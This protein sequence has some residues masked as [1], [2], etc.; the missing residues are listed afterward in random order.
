M[1]TSHQR[2]PKVNMIV[3]MRSKSVCG[4]LFPVDKAQEL[5]P[6]L[7]RRTHT[8]EHTASG[9]A[10]SRLL[11]SAHDHAEMARFYDYGDALRLQHLGESEC[12]LLGKPL[13]DLEATGEHLGDAGKFREA[14]Y[15]TIGYI[16]NVHLGLL[17]S[18]GSGPTR[19]RT[20][21]MKG[22]RWCSHREKI[23]MS[24]TMTSSS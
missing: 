16:S 24:L 18:C 21:P 2:R 12:Y 8:A 13:L 17:A 9:C 15:A 3:H 23:S 4:Q 20:F 22:T 19:R 5:L 14:N 6:S 7:G 1:N 11:D 10:G